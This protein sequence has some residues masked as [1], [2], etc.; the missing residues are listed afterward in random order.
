MCLPLPFACGV[1][2]VDSTA[3][4]EHAADKLEERH[5]LAEKEHGEYD[6]RY[7]LDISAD[8]DGADGELLHGREVEITAK[9]R[10]DDTEHKDRQVIVRA[11]GRERALLGED[12]GGNDDA[13]TEE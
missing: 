6:C 7:R 4:N 10:I 2:A 1:F 8:G 5:A 13:C 12:E 9:A 3:Q 11:Y